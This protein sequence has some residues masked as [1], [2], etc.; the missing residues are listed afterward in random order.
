MDTTG[1]ASPCGMIDYPEAAFEGNRGDSGRGEW[2]RTGWKRL[3]VAGRGRMEVAQEG[4]GDVQDLRDRQAVGLDDEVGVLACVGEAASLF[5]E[6]S[7]GPVQ[8]AAECAYLE[9]GIQEDE[10]IGIR[11][12]LPHE[13]DV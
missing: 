1:A 4:E 6:I 9:R 11:D 12:A 10:D 13:W 5:F 7:R 8:P 2:A 3:L